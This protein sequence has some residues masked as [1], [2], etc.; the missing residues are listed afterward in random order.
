MVC[1]ASASSMVV[2]RKVM[3]VLV[4]EWE[5]LCIVAVSESVSMALASSGFQ[6][7]LGLLGLQP[8]NEQVR[9]YNIIMYSGERTDECFMM[10]L[11]L[12][13]FDVPDF[14]WEFL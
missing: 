13:N 3:F 5:E 10:A 11:S 14:W 8:P 2:I 7:L 4:D 9:C 1:L 6:Q 12:K